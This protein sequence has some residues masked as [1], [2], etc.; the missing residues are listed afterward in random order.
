MRALPV[1]PCVLLL[2][3]L[4]RAEEAL[5]GVE[6]EMTSPRD[7]ALSLHLELGAASL[8][9][10]A[11]QPGLALSLVGAAVPASVSVGVAIGEACTVAADVWTAAAPD[12]W[13]LA[14]GVP[15]ASSGLGLQLVL[16]PRLLDLF[17]AFS[18]S[19][20][21]LAIRADRGTFVVRTGL[22]FGAK[23]AAGKEWRVGSRWMLALAVEA[24]ATARD[25][26]GAGPPAFAAG[27]AFSATY[28]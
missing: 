5:Q 22:G 21:V 6:A 23:L 17:V 14:R 3:S 19:A 16:R 4:C 7:V 18:P 9:R 8:T 11:A 20:A 26:G 28:D 10:S 25:P 15:L 1:I 2:A 27:L 13:G 24:L 12:P